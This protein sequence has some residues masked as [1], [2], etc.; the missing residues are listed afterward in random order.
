MKTVD[1]RKY[2]EI[3]QNWE[4]FKVDPGLQQKIDLIHSIIPQK[5][6]SILDI[7]CGNGL[8]TNDLFMKY[9][10]FALDRSQSALQY[11][12]APKV[13]AEANFLPIKSKSI[14]LVF[15]SELLEHLNDT[16]LREAINEVQRTA[17]HYILISV[18]NQEMLEKNTL[19]CPECDT[20]FNVSYHFQTFDSNRLK[21]LFSEF[22]CTEIHEV[23]PGWRRY[24]PILL[25]IRQQWGNGWFKIPPQRQV[26]CPTCNCRNFPRFKMNPIIFFCDGMNKLLT[27]RRPYWLVALYKRKSE[28]QT[29]IN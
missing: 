2:Y 14:D 23:G 28:N 13:N 17:K 20:I 29:C 12:D 27:P 8:I 4:Q 1:N 5:I 24:I 6:D 7:G 10:V 16:I 3:E 15:S 22:T 19:K 25:N 11:V 18:P 26:M 9:N 21:N